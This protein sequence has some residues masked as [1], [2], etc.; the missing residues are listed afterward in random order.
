M[1]ARSTGSTTAGLGLVNA[2]W[3]GAHPDWVA[4]HPGRSLVAGTIDGDS[5]LWWRIDRSPA[6]TGL[7]RDTL[8]AADGSGNGIDGNVKPYRQAGVTTLMV[9]VAAA[10]WFRVPAG[11]AR[12]PD[13]VGVV[14]HGVVYMGEQKKIA[15]ARRLR[16]AGP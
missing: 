8:L 14:Q 15:R 3:A 16:P 4:A 2:A 10:A 6:A 5:L 1:Q 7:V 9:G 12:V 11:D 13:V